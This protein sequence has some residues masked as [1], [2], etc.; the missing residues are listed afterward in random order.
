MHHNLLLKTVEEET[1]LIYYPSEKNLLKNKLR[2]VTP[3]HEEGNVTSPI[4]DK[5]LAK[6]VHKGELSTEQQKELSKLAYSGLITNA[7]TP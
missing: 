2:T 5:A 7:P 3:R 6:L 1:K 4:V